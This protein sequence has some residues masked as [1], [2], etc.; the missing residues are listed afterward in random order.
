M[1]LWVFALP[2]PLAFGWTAGLPELPEPD[3]VL[4][5]PEPLD[6]V[7]PEDEPEL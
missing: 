4:M 3:P 5:E 7:L 2:E 6:P 1:L